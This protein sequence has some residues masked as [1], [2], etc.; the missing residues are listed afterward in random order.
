[1]FVRT[2]E[3]VEVEN[4]TLAVTRRARAEQDESGGTAI[5]EGAVQIGRL[6]VGNLEWTDH[7]TGVRERDEEPCCTDREDLLSSRFS[8]GRELIGTV[9][10]LISSKAMSA[11]T[12]ATL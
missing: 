6:P 8:S 11:A 2:D 4:G 1:M 12:L 10:A 9:I 7:G 5:T 3:L